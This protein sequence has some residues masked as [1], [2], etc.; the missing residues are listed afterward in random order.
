MWWR[1][2]FDTADGEV[3]TPAI[4]LVLAFLVATGCAVHSEFVL[5]QPQIAAYSGGCAALVT[6]FA[7][8]GAFKNHF[9]KGGSDVG[10]AEG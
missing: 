10:G 6:A 7:G 2:F 1:Q 3:D 5:K 4:L 9:K 8:V